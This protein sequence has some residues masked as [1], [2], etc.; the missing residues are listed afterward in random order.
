VDKT[1]VGPDDINLQTEEFTLY[2]LVLIV[3]PE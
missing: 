1:R 2:Y 3:S